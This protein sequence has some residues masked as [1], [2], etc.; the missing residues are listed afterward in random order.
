MVKTAETPSGN[1]SWISANEENIWANA[2]YCVALSLIRQYAV[3]SVNEKEAKIFPIA[4]DDLL[5]AVPTFSDG[6]V[7]LTAER[8]SQLLIADILLDLT[9]AHLQVHDHDLDP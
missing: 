3:M 6:F 7:G 2:L 4:L 8:K 5:R 1:L 9:Q